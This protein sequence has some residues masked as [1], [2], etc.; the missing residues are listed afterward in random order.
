MNCLLCDILVPEL[1]EAIIR[2]NKQ[3][4]ELKQIIEDLKNDNDVNQGGATLRR[5]EGD[6]QAG[7]V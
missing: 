1:E 7:A 5:E 4:K 2:L 3:N 6:S